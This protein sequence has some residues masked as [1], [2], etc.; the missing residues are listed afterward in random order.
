MCIGSVV[1]EMQRNSL[2]V[3]RAQGHYQNEESAPRRSQWLIPNPSLRPHLRALTHVKNLMKYTNLAQ[4][5]R[6]LGS[7]DIILKG[8]I[9]HQLFK[10]KKLCLLFGCK[11]ALP[12]SRIKSKNSLLLHLFKLLNPKNLQPWFI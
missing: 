3:G 10:S 2:G 4:N 9:L 7:M 6:H 8:G 11:E 12:L 1:K 5:Q